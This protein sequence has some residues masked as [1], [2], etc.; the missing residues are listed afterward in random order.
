MNTKFETP[1]YYYGV[2]FDEIRETTRSWGP[3]GEYYHYIYLLEGKIVAIGREEG[4]Y[5]GGIYCSLRGSDK[6][7]LKKRVEGCENKEIRE[8]TAGLSYHPTG[9]PQKENKSVISTTDLLNMEETYVKWKGV[10]PITDEDR[11]EINI[12]LTQASNFISKHKGS[13]Q[14]VDYLK[15]IARNA[16]AQIGK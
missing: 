16:I 9:I 15:H 13:P 14:I 2:F 8:M 5:A 3:R 1:H 6:A 10:V 7:T 12:M 4:N 11:V